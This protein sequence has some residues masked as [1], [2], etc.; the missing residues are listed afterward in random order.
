[1]YIYFYRHSSLE[2]NIDFQICFQYCFFFL[3]SLY[4]E[5][6]ELIASLWLVK[7]ERMVRIRLC[8]RKEKWLRIDERKRP[9]NENIQHVIFFFFVRFLHIIIKLYI[10]SDFLIY[11]KFI[12]DNWEARITNIIQWRCSPIIICLPKICDDIRAKLLHDFVAHSYLLFHY[13]L[14]LYYSRTSNRWF[15]NWFIAFQ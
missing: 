4:R 7:Y 2:W 13:Q 14:D 9:R 10:I 3:L 15:S 8:A 5:R 6:E 12:I 11:F 1:M